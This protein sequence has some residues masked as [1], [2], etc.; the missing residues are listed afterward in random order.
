MDN[1]RKI[2]VLI[3]LIFLLGVPANSLELE[4]NPDECTYI[5]NNIENP[6]DKELAYFFRGRYYFEK[7]E[8][9][10]AIPDFTNSIKLAKP[11]SE[12]Q[13]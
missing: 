9:K 5:I 6:E 3:G 4:N 11:N 10:K 7:K 8:Y 12:Y 2:L 1:I 13:G